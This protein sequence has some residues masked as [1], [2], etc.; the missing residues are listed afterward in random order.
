MKATYKIYLDGCAVFLESQELK[1]GV[2]KIKSDLSISKARDL[3]DEL[4][5]A[6]RQLE[7]KA[8]ETFILEQGI[9]K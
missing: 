3:V 8:V 7:S 6:I 9:K 5:W 1:G 4:N 2:M